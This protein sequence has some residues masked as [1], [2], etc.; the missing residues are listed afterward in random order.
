MVILAK[1]AQDCQEICRF[2]L[3][4]FPAPCGVYCNN[5][6]NPSFRLLAQE[7]HNFKISIL[8]LD[9]AVCL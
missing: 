3:S 6:F 1:D 2:L 8:A 5:P 4:S 7:A 9:P